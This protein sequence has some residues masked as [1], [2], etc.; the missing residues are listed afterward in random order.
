M[1]GIT[2]LDHV[3]SALY[4]ESQLENYLQELKS[5]VY[6]NPHSRNASSKHTTQTIDQMRDTV[7]QYF[8]VN[9]N[10]YS[11]I[12]T[13][14]C[15]DAL[16][17]IHDSFQ[18]Y[19]LQQDT[20]E[21]NSDKDT[22]NSYATEVQ[23]CF[24]YLE[25][26]HTSVIGIRQAIPPSNGIITCVSTQAV[27]MAD[28]TNNKI[29]CQ[30]LNSDNLPEQQSI[31]ASKKITTTDNFT[32]N[33]LFAYPAQSNFSGRKYPLQ[34]IDKI[35]SA[36]LIPKCVNTGKNDRWYVLL[37]AASY[38]STSRLDLK[39]YKADFIPISFYKL[40]GFPTGLGALIVRNDAAEVLKKQYFGGGTIET[41]LYH[42]D[43]T[44]FKTA[45]HEKLVDISISVIH[46]TSPSFAPHQ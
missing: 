39:R 32:I 25:D 44:S 34:W 40:F 43:F 27:E 38:I 2:Y 16:K 30:P 28:T 33:H 26:N 31:Q 5:Q 1:I 45:F 22:F 36:Q 14:G 24:C 21:F 35:R 13:S 17:I 20:D 41:C 7:L 4:C 3:G 37:D 10:D 8:N 42:A 11:L 12:F 46:A 19:N 9:S 29:E 23:P 6:S 18:W 15:T